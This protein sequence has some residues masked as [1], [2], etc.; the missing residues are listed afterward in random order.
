MMRVNAELMCAECYDELYRV[1]DECGA[2]AES[3]DL[4]ERRNGDM[5]C[6]ACSSRLESAL[7][8]ESETFKINRSRRFAGVELEFIG[9]E[10][11][12]CDTIDDYG[13]LKE[14]GS[15]SDED[16]YGYEF[17]MF[18]SNGDRLL[19]RIRTVCCEYSDNYINTTCGVHVHIDM[20]GTNQQQRDNVYRHFS[21][22]ESAIMG[23]VSNSRD[24]NTYC[25]SLNNSWERY[26]T[27]RYR[28]LNTTSY[29]KFG[30]YEFRFHQ[31]TLNPEKVNNLAMFLLNFVDTFV[32]VNLERQEFDKIAKLTNREKLL[33]LFQQV[34]MPL[35]LKKYMVKKI[36]KF[37]KYSLRREH[38]SIKKDTAVGQMDMSA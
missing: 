29:S 25:V 10:D 38:E 31:G 14:D 5:V 6:R 9:M 28:T 15:L 21:A 27:D 4:V 26:N 36:R 30:T 34:K 16:G 35:K 2:E 11:D 13:H 17:A 8:F 23:M 33:Y 32:N 1:C 37:G 18:P 3:S 19:K 7:F 22:L 24:T 20:K 12:Y